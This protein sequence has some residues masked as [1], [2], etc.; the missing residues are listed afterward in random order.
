MT[1]LIASKYDTTDCFI[2][3]SIN[4]YNQLLKMTAILLFLRSFFNAW[5]T[6]TRKHI[7]FFNPNT[8]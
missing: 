1:L 8:C 6:V 4:L 3:L 5:K 2:T 7:F